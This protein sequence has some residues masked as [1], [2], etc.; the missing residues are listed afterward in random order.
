MHSR[1]I[2]VVEDDPSSWELCAK[3]LLEAGFQVTVA[4]TGGEAVHRLRNT[5]FD[6]VITSALMPDVGGLIFAAVKAF[7]LS[8]P[9]VLLSRTP[10]KIRCLDSWGPTRVLAEPFTPAELLA[11][12]QAMLPHEKRGDRRRTHA[13]RRAANGPSKVGA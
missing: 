13:R 5:Q 11:V 3:I 6:L 10:N 4:G 12:V 1:Q 7:D 2:L 8:T 9:V